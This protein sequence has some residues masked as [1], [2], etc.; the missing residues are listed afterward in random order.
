MIKVILLSLCLVFPFTAHA[1]KLPLS[2][3]VQNA[4]SWLRD[5]DTMKARFVQTT[6][7]GQRLAGT[8]YLDRPGKLRFEYDA[9]EDFIVADGFFIYYY[10]SEIEE[11]SN[12]PIGQTLAD[13]LLR[14]NLY[15]SGEIRVSEARRAG[16]YL[17]IS[18]VQNEDPDAGTLSL[19]FS[20]DPLVLKKW[21]VV[22]P[23][24]AITEV[25]LYGIEKEIPLDNSLFIYR[26]P[27]QDRNNPYRVNQ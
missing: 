6:G 19:A 22:D 11:Q 8:F 16:G 25:E 26:D 12:A 9:L 7:D 24:G 13:F 1:A 10:D 27:K 5:L 4:E 23:V 15:F 20:E 14:E 2:Q 18:L 17:Q 21:R 3:A